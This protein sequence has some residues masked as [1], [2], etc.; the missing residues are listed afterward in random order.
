MATRTF[1][2]IVSGGPRGLRGGIRA[3]QLGKKVVIVE[4][5]HLGGICLNWGCIPTKALLRS[6]EVFHLFHRAK[7]FG[8]K[9]E[10]PDFDF[11]AVI[12]RSR[13]VAKQ[14]SGGVRG[15]MRKNKIDV[16]MG[17]A[18]LTAPGRVAVT[19]DKGG[20]E[21][22]GQGGGARDRRAGAGPA[23][24]RARRRPDL[25]LQDRAPAA[26]DAQEPPGD[27][28]GRHR[29]RVRELLQ[30]DGRQG[31]RSWRSWT[32]SCPWRTPRCRPSPGSSSR[33]RA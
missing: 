7:E 26:A 22:G 24:A 2:V 11:P 3:A 33:S 20:E 18:T 12:Q 17:A 21:L 15:L 4:R 10:K 16:V 32:A 23:G 6:A 8:L 19:T 13:A 9:V 28:L 30:H 25:G 27:R 5:E 31:R 29:H 1:D 14:L